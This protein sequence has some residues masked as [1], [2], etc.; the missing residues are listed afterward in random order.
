MLKR[1]RA[2]WKFC[3]VAKIRNLQISQ[4]C[5]SMPA[6]D[7]FLTRLFMV[8]YKSTLD[9]G[10]FIHFCNFLSTEHLYKL[11]L[12]CKSIN[13]QSINQSIK[14]GTELPFP[15]LVCDLLSLSFI[16]LYF[17]GNQTPLDDDKSRD[18]RLK[19]PSP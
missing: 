14:L 8:L 4:H 16:F 2:Q 11:S 7:C 18:A 3:R 19:P 9:F 17:L 15:R 13:F 1:R 5:S 10:S 12:V 6:I